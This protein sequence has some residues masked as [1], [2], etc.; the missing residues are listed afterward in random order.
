MSEAFSVQLGDMLRLKRGHDLPESVRKDGD[1][2]V[3]SSSGITGCHNESKAK[4]PGV[5]TG[6]YGTLGEVYY[7]EEDYWPLNTALYVAD[8]KG[9]NPRFIAY[10]LQNVLKSYQ[11]DKA[12]VPGVNR[13]VLHKLKVLC[14]DKIS[15]ERIA[16]ILSS[17]DQ[18]IAINRRRIQL[19]EESAR[20]LYRE[21]FVYFRFP[22]Y[23]K[24]KLVDCKGVHIPGVEL[25]T[26]HKD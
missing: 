11:S 18:F 12:A 23:E 5:V 4:A 15:H 17:Y 22:G 21:W 1:I 16:E 20:L 26:N 19:L 24:V 10:F 9:N 25:F 3:V 14:P 6:R 2:P 7:L 13:N 8:F